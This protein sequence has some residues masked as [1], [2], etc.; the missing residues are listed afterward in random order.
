M[1]EKFVR[2]APVSQEE[3][4]NVSAAGDR[5]DQNGIKESMNADQKNYNHHMESTTRQEDN[6][7]V[8]LQQQSSGTVQ[9]ELTARYVTGYSNQQPAW[10]LATL[11]FLG[12]PYVL[13][14]QPT[15][16]CY[17]SLCPTVFAGSYHVMC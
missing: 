2:P 7:N 1:L 16:S 17:W 4:Q 6:H 13:L 8:E 14:Y 12:G 15:S 3:D 10:Y 9:H 5:G 11:C